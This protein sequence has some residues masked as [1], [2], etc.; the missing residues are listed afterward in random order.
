MV[1]SGVKEHESDTTEFDLSDGL[2]TVG[3]SW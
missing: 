3:N 2:E 1:K